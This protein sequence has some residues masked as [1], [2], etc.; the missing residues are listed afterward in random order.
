MRIKAE[1]ALILLAALIPSAYLAWRYAD[2]PHLGHFHD[3]GVYLTTARSLAEGSGYRILSLPGEPNQIKFPPLYPAYVA[4]AWRLNPFPANLRWITL[5]TWLLLPALLAALMIFYRGM[6]FDPVKCACLAAIVALSPHTALLAQSVMSEI[7]A[8][9]LVVCSLSAAARRTTRSAVVAGVFAGAAFLTRSA[10]V[11][12]LPGLVLYYLLNKQKRAALCFALS[13]APFAAAWQAWAFLLRPQA[14]TE[15]ILFYATYMGHWTANFSLVDIPAL[16]WKNTGV[17]LFGVGG[18]LVYTVEPD[19]VSGN[20]LRLATYG[21]VAGAVRLAFRNGLSPYHCFAIFYIPVVLTWIYAPHERFVYPLLPLIAAGFV[22][23]AGHLSSMLRRALRHSQWSQR[24]VASVL[25]GLLVCLTAYAAWRA[26]D[27]LTQFLPLVFEQ[28]RT[29]RAA[30][31]E[32]SRWIVQNTPKDAR[33]IAYNDPVLF[34]YTGRK[35]TG[36]HFPPRLA[37]EGGRSQVVEYFA[38]AAAFARRNNYPYLLLTPADFGQDLSPEERI[39]VRKRLR[40][41]LPAPEYSASGVH[42]YR[43]S[44]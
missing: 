11:A 33:F 13:M 7:M 4:L 14:V 15:D 38:S 42:V 35:A 29:L 19:L 36:V 12:I 1:V 26:G 22:T 43:L 8:T 24:A 9:L 10:T 5:L 21:A 25:I 32:A 31:E 23:E 27:G 16:V 39:E 44:R 2:M 18:L 28:A 30:Q 40:A 34:L 37:Y 6:G 3:D 17:F 20:L 41:E